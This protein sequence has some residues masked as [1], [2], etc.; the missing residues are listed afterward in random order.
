MPESPSNSILA[1]ITGF[2][3]LS[4][5]L[6][7]DDLLSGRTHSQDFRGSRADYITLRVR[8]IAFT[9]AIITP[10]WIPVD[11]ELMS[12]H[13]AEMMTLMRIVATLLFAVLGLWSRTRHDLFQAR[14]KLVLLI[15]LLGACHIGSH[16]ILNSNNVY[17]LLVAYTFLPYLLIAIQ[18]IFPLTV[19]ESFA[20]V[21][22]AIGMVGGVELYSGKLLHIPV[23]TELWLMLLLAGIAL[24]AQMT[25]LHM[26]LS[27]YRQATRDPLT[28]LYNRRAFM[29]RLDEEINRSQRYQRPLSIL[30]FDLDRF[31]RINDTYGHLTGDR[32][33]NSFARLLTGSLRTS[34][35]CGRYGGEEFLVLLPETQVGAALELAERIRQACATTPVQSA[36]TEQPVTVT[37]TVSGGVAELTDRETPDELITR[38]DDSLYEAKKKGR[39]QVVRV[40]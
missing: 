16:L 38:V 40:R 13:Q 2:K 4:P 11:Y 14:L 10:V 8:I 7:L 33:L 17:G 30:M 35:L 1:A 28:G 24:W 26:L 27:L 15:L 6:V 22:I 25:Q 9:L 19:L 32:V 34:D 18:A 20:L 21:I 23:L 37:V 39:N 31:K 3:L 5:N 29:E 36:K 12:T